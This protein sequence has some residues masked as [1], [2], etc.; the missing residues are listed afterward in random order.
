MLF[1]TFKFCP[2]IFDDSGSQ[3]LDRLGPCVLISQIQIYC[4]FV[5]IRSKQ[6]KTVLIRQYYLLSFFSFE[7]SFCNKLN[8]QNVRIWVH[9]F[10][11]TYGS[12]DPKNSTIYRSG[13]IWKLIKYRQ[14]LGTVPHQWE[15][16]YCTNFKC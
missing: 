13:T 15:S 1:I 6:R 14:Q 4:N 16:L 7:R 11:I 10:D 5:R 8:R 2:N 12:Q 9:N 3:D